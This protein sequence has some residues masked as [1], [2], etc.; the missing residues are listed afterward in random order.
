MELDDKIV[1]GVEGLVCL[2][3]PVEML[4]KQERELRKDTYYPQFLL[5]TVQDELGQGN[6]VLDE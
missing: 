5:E 4:R 6:V 2:S 3:T 1:F